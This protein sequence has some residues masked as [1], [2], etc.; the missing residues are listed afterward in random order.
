MRA[1]CSSNENR[2]GQGVPACPERG[3]GKCWFPCEPPRFPPL[4]ASLLAC[5]DPH[6]ETRHTSG[7]ERES[8]WNP[9][10]SGAGSFLLGADK[11]G[12]I[13]LQRSGVCRGWP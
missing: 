9:A 4:S 7:L 5:L 6:L 2:A 10:L 1:L 12:P 11:P 13:A 8:R 3:T